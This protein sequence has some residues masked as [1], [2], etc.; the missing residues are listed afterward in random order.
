MSLVPVEEWS[1]EGRTT[2]KRRRKISS[3]LEPEEQKPS[4]PAEE[5]ISKTETE[6][7][8]NQAMIAVILVMRRDLD[9]IRAELGEERKS[10]L[11][12]SYYWDESHSWG[13]DEEEASDEY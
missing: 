12:E 2:E 11:L 7:V 1:E 10:A 3:S 8:T 13:S 9:E 5:S 6:E 4:V